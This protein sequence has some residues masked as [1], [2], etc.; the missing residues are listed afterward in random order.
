MATLERSARL[1]ILMYHRILPVADA[2]RP[3]ETTVDTFAWHM[4]L[5]KKFFNPL[6]L[7]EAAE[8]LAAG[9]LPPRAI[10][11]TFDDGYADNLKLALPVLK[12]NDVPATVF[13]STAYLDGGCM[14]NDMIIEAVRT[15]EGNV[16]S[17]PKLG[18]DHLPLDTSE[19][20]YR[21][22]RSVIRAVKHLDFAARED[23][24]NELAADSEPK[25]CDLMLSTRELQTLAGDALI[26]IGAHTHRHPILSTLTEQQAL[27]EIQTSKSIL[28]S[29]IGT[30]IKSFAYPNGRPGK[31]FTDRDPELVRSLG[32]KVAVTTQVGV[33]VPGTDLLCLPRFTPWD[34]TPVRFLLRMLRIR[35][36]T[37]V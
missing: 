10:C 35:Q 13:V 26:T 12:A 17:L 6:P 5:I 21:A 23:F 4:G 29:K 14:W 9:T 24:A 16:L 15:R 7:E 28:E 3:D 32:F 18:I 30:E 25:P 33:G 8:R 36:K 34:P 27:D 19:D 37:V 31:D 20:R 2:L 1:S 22:V 11:V